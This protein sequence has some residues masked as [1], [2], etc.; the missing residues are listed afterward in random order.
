MTNRKKSTSKAVQTLAEPKI[1]PRPAPLRIRRGAQRGDCVAWAAAMG[2]SS[3]ERGAER[4]PLSA[5]ALT[6]SPAEPPASAR[7]RTTTAAKPPARSASSQRPEAQGAAE[8]PGAVALAALEPILNALTTILQA[9]GLPR[10]ASD[11]LAATS[12]TLIQVLQ[13]QLGVGVALTHRGPR[14]RAVAAAQGMAQL[15]ELMGWSVRHL[16]ITRATHPTRQSHAFGFSARVWVAPRPT[17]A[18]FRL[19]AASQII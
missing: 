17:A 16:D 4:A 1:L 18:A 10:M 3:R 11:P 13:G 9:V 14:E 5:P 2:R 6:S 15:V 12:P 19:P 7:K 8:R